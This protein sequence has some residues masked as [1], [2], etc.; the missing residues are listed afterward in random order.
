MK[1]APSSIFMVSPDHFGFNAETA[2]SNAF[3][4]EIL[5][6]EDQHVRTAALKEFQI[7]VDLLHLHDVQVMTFH[8]PH[9][10]HAPDAVFPNNW[11]SMHEDGRMILYPMLTP[12][13]RIE[14]NPQIVDEIK[15]K[16]LVKEI[17]DLTLEESK[18]RILEGTGSIV[19]DHINKMAYA[20]QS[21]RTDKS[22]FYDVCEF[23][24]YSGIFFKAV[25]QKGFDI[26]HT[27]VLMTIGKGYA[28]ICSEAIDPV[29]RPE[30]L[31]QLH[32]S[33]L[34]VIGI[35]YQQ[36][37]QFAGNMIQ[38]ETRKGDLILVMSKSAFECLTEDQK[39]RLEKY[40]N[41]VFSDIHTIESVGGGSARCMIAGIHLPP[42]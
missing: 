3:Q 10:Q 37:S 16:F 4:K 2:K 13:R 20:N 38:L 5:L 29:D 32:G 22:L 19:F 28:V 8:S 18:G 33:G 7:L 39:R 27:N 40:N 36:M 14:R 15:K 24:G 1:Q 35:T 31:N 11:I 17:V 12:N 23:L 41:L 9:G 21:S 42:V 26:Y 30:V 6:C 25:D 34:E